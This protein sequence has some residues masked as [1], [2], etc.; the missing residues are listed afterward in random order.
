MCSKYHGHT[1]RPL[2]MS[3]IVAMVMGGTCVQKTRPYMYVL[4]SGYDVGNSYCTMAMVGTCVQSITAIRTIIRLLVYTHVGS[5][6]SARMREGY[7]T[8]LVCLCVCLS[9][10]ALAASASV[11][12]SKQRYSQVSRRPT[13]GS[14]DLKDNCLGK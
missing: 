6:A 9:V 2:L 3:L 4:L 14:N 8:C 13:K 11:E 10:P 12:T 1:Y 5:S 7:C